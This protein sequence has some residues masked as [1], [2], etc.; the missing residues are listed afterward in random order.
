MPDS[1]T[2]VDVAQRRNPVRRAAAAM[3]FSIATGM[4]LG[5]N[6]SSLTFWDSGR[7]SYWR[8]LYVEGERPREFVKIE[9]QIPP[10][11]RVAST[12]F[13]HPRYTHFERSYDYSAY[14]RQVAGYEDRVPDDTDYIVIDTRHPYSRVHSPA[15]VRELQREPDRWELLPDV[16]NGYFIVLKRRETDSP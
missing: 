14:A 6:P 15:D 8:N 2:K 10:S 7:G 11:A 9:T 12:D 1:P 13:V 16:T 5:T 4:F 3:L